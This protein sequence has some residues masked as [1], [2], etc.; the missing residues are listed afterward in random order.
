MLLLD[1]PFGALD[2]ALR[3]HMQVELRKLQQSISI[4]T[5]V[6]THD[7]HEAFTLSDLIAVMRAGRIEQIGTP[8]RSTTGQAPVSSRSSWAS[9]TCWPPRVERVADGAV[10]V[11]AGAI[12]MRCARGAA[13]Q[14]GDEA[15]I[16]VRADAIVIED[17]PSRHDALPARVTYAT[18]QGGAILYELVLADGQI[19]RAAEARR[20]DGVRPP[21][22]MVGVRLPPS[23][24][25][26]VRT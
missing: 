3:G 18:H 5:L 17:M 1:E 12:A 14:S 26:A 22:T 6:V 4:T 16:A 8:S 21:G 20:G 10:D 15:I 9:R 7:Q 11:R 19:L 13:L 2:Q 23:R 24:C 25:T